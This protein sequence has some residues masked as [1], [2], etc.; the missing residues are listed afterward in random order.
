[1]LYEFL[2]EQLGPGDTGAAAMPA[3]APPMP[4]AR[5]SQH[6]L[7]PADLA[8]AWRGPQPRKEAR[9]D[10]AGLSEPIREPEQP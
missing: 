5:P 3:E 4:T 1:M 9:R 6:T 2:N 8:P 7:T 10:R